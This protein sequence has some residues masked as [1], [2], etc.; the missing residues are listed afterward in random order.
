MHRP[1]DPQLGQAEVGDLPVGHVVGDHADDLAAGGE[2]GVGHHA[3]EPHPAAAVD[4]VDPALHQCRR[5]RPGRL[6]VLRTG[7]VL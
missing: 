4:E 5:H 6:G 2:H 3:H 1:D 7:A